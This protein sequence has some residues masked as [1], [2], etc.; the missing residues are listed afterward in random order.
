[1]ELIAKLAEE[2][3]IAKVL[4]WIDHG[5]ALYFVRLWLEYEERPDWMTDVIYILGKALKMK[6]VQ[7]LK[8]EDSKEK[9]DGRTRIKKTGT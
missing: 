8:K 7:G 5:R 9:D 3:G 6:E 4:P 2:K 1:M